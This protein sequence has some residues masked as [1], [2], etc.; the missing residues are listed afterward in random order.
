[1]RLLADENMPLPV[2]QGL[3]AAGHD[4]RWIG[5]EDPGL[6]DRAVLQHAHEEER[7]LLTFDTDFGTLTFHE[8]MDTPAGIVL[9][10]LPPLGKDELVRFVVDTVEARDD[11]HGHF[12]VIEQHRIRMRPLPNP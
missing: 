4:V 12:A 5:D 10:R 3:R 8:T 11:W 9:F 6:G 7:I 2:V 1:M